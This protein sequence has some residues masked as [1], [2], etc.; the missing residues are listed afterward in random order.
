MMT[1]GTSSI[2]IGFSI[3]S[4]AFWGFPV[5]FLWFGVSPLNVKGTP[6]AQE[7]PI[8]LVPDCMA[9]EPLGGAEAAAETKRGPGKNGRWPYGKTK[10]TPGKMENWDVICV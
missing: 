10:E 9:A 3:L 7:P 4:Q 5:V 8:D 1:G 6:M 2:F